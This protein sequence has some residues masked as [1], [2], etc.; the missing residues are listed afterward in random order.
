[1]T[2]VFLIKYFSIDITVNEY[3]FADSGHAEEDV[4]IFLCG[5]KVEYFEITFG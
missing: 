2:K 1:M 3:F 5:G 4:G